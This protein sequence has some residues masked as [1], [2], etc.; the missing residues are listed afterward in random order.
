M[1]TKTRAR[2]EARAKILKAMAHPSRLLIIDELAAGERCVCDLTEMVGADMS[3]VSKHLSVL[4]S[5]GLV[6]DDKRGLQVFYSLRVPC[7]T[8]LFSCIEG[9]VKSNAE[10][11]LAAL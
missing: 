9:V 11:H 2:Y 4:K 10:A 5:A 8:S 6:S 3:T 7:A 1:D